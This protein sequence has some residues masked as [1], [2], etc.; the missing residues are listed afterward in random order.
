MYNPKDGGIILCKEN[1]QFV[2]CVALRR[3]DATTCELKRMYVQPGQQGKGIGKTLLEKSLQL[4]K[5]CSYFF[6]RLDTLNDMLPAISLYKAKG[7]YE[8]PAYYY[9][10]DERAVFYELK[11]QEI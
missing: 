7:F 10:P 8:I 11:L 2:A 3:I 9:N 4:A 6:M 5:D 1:T